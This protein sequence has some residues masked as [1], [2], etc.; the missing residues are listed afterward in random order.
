[1]VELQL[2]YPTALDLPKETETTRRSPTK[3]SPGSGAG[4]SIDRRVFRPL[5]CR[6]DHPAGNYVVGPTLNQ[7]SAS[8]YAYDVAETMHAMVGE[9]NTFPG[10]HVEIHDKGFLQPPDPWDP[11]DHDD[12]Q[13][14]DAYVHDDMRHSYSAPSVRASTSRVPWQASTS[15]R[16]GLDPGTWLTPQ[17][18]RPRRTDRVSRGAQMRATWSRDRFLRGSACRKFDLRGCGSIGGQVP[19]H[20][21]LLIPDYVPPHEKRRDLLR[22]QVRQQMR[23][24]DLV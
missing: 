7:D 8:Y 2:R 10:A 20:R 3:G 15:C 24:A 13:V 11:D 19:V 4:V 9:S 17:M 1:M 18:R 23:H 22:M 14:D 21:S 6:R 12:F 5:R 16:R